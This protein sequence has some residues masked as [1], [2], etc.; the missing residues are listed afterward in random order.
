MTAAADRP[1]PRLL[2]LGLNSAPEPVG[3]GPYTAG[4]CEALVA[5]GWQVRA[6]SGTPYYP[7]WEAMADH[8]R[9]WHTR[10]ENGVRIT[11]C[12]HHIPK[13]PGGAKR[14]LHHASFA[15]SAQGPVLATALRW[16]PDVVMTVAPS[17]MSVPI[18]L[19]AA[20]VGKARSWI[21]VQDFEVEAAIAT[22][23]VSRGSAAARRALAIE[24]NLLQRADVVST[25]SPQMRAKLAEKGVAS[26]AIFE[27]RNWANHAREAPRAGGADYRRQWGLTGKSVALYSGNIANKQGLDVVV[28]A[29]S[30]LHHRGDI[31]FVICGEG[32]GRQ[33]IEAMLEGMPNVQLHDLQPAER[34]GELLAMADVHLLPQLGAA[35]DL[36]LPSKL[37]NILA[38][39]R[40]VVATAHPGTGLAGEVAGRGLVVEPGNAEALARAVAQLID[41]PDLARKLGDAGALRARSHWTRDAIID[42]LDARLR[43]EI[44]AAA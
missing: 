23:M 15:A 36:V 26:E 5:R 43:E 12:P 13:N 17:L 21:H 41:D 11:R 37:T 7:R 8:P 10:T 24:G 14:L 35:A 22:G 2:V 29:A 40:P 30:S 18:G 32:A 16:K 44:G 25:I 1:Q 4:M 19:A 6:I 20:K 34:V 31:V 27:L 28:D 39:G 42:S 9:G 33:R 38:S 3:I